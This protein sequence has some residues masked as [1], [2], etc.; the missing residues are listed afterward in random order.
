MQVRVG[1]PRVAAWVVDLPSVRAPVRS[2]ISKRVARQRSQDVCPWNV[3]FARAL[4]E[5]SPF[6]ARDALAGK[7]TRTG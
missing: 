2:G 3:R 5:G 7:D 4:P 1:A 6:A